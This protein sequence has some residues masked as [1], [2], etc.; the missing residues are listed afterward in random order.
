MKAAALKRVLMSNEPFGKIDLR[1]WK[2]EALNELLLSRRL[3]Q[4]L[5]AMAAEV[6]D[7]SMKENVTAYPEDSQTGRINVV[8]PFDSG[9]AEV[10]PHYSFE[11]DD[12]RYQVPELENPSAWVEKLRD[13]ADEIETRLSRAH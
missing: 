2:L 4:L 9:L 13:I 6:I 8:F 3:Q 12:L 11:L 1:E 5:L 10:G 7:Y